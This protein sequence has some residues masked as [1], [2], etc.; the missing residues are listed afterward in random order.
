MRGRERER[1]KRQQQE[2]EK[3]EAEK[4]RK[5]SSAQKDYCPP[6]PVYNPTFIGDT[7]PPFNN[8]LPTPDK[9]KL[10]KERKSNSVKDF[11]PPGPTHTLSYEDTPALANNL[12][13]KV[14]PPA[15][16]N[17]EE[18]EKMLK[19][20]REK[21]LKKTKMTEYRQKKIQERM[22]MMMTIQILT[23]FIKKKH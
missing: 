6:G 22:L 3:E 2:R 20:A 14:A 12:V 9:E 1:K 15:K 23:T 17:E 10:E 8:L 19:R 11:Y 5:E 13:Q 21:M 16:T 4:K 7:L 18:R